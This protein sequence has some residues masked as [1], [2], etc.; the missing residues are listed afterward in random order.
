MLVRNVVTASVEVGNQGVF[1]HAVAVVEKVIG[2][3]GTLLR[4]NVL[5]A[6]HDAVC[7]QGVGNRVSENNFG[8]I[9]VFDANIALIQ[10]IKQD[11]QRQK[12]NGNLFNGVFQ[13][14]IS[15][16]FSILS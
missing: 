9:G 8:T 3:V 2:G 14:P 12:R 4:K 1:G 15:L 10:H 6:D 7:T 11:H 5:V 13:S 16:R